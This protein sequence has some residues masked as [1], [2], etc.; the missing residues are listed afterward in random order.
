MIHRRWFVA[1]LACSS[2]W[3][4]AGAAEPGEG[5]LT[6]PLRSRTQPFK[7]SDAWEEIAL[8]KEFNPRETAII[9]CD[10]WDKHWCDSA[11]GRCDALAKKMA[12]VIAAARAKGVTIVHAPSDTMEYYK[13]SPARKRVK[14]A[15]R[16]EMPKALQL[17]DPPL[18]IDDSD[19]GCDDPNPSKSF[20]AWKRQHAAII[21]DEERDGVSDNGQEIYNFL[22]PKGVKNLFIMGVHTNMC[23]LHRSFAIKPMTRIGMKCV[24]V[25]DLT[26]AMYNPRMRPMVSH[27][28]GTEKI[29]QHIEKYWCPTC[30]ST[31]LASAVK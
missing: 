13:D 19:G 17:P 8:K 5:S 15:A 20:R 7:G 28:E 11:T 29:I 16:V 23:V 4:P 6:L 14:E 22:Q 31:D 27:A 18:P 21:V 10:V 24:L 3:L 2:L 26:D 1:V 30:L 12:P 25:R 9:I